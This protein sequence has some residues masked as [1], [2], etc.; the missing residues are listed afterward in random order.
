M[1]Q[2]ETVHVFATL[3][4]QPGQADALRQALRVLVHATR[5]EP[6]CLD[7]ALHEDIKS[8]G[9]FFIHETYQNQAAV[10]AHMAAPHLALALS[11]AGTMLREPPQIATTQLISDS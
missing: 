7:Y 3:H 11:I 4:A 9:S 6:G 10:D 8:L 2:T 5:T 1:S